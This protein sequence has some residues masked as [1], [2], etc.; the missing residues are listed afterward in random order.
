[1]TKI[2]IMSSD[3]G[4]LAERLSAMKLLKMTAAPK[5]YRTVPP[6]LNPITETEQEI[7][8]LGNFKN[9]PAA[10]SPLIYVDRGMIVWH[11]HSGAGRVHRFYEMKRGATPPIGG[12]IA[13]VLT[14]ADD[15][16]VMSEST[17][18]VQVSPDLSLNF[19]FCRL[20]GGYVSVS[21]ATTSTTATTLTGLGHAGAWVDTR[22]GWQSLTQ[23]QNSVTPTLLATFSVCKKDGITEENLEDGIMAVA[24]GDIPIH[25]TVVN[26]WKTEPFDNAVFS[27]PN[28]THDV[29]QPSFPSGGGAY[30]VLVT[31]WVSPWNI[32]RTFTTEPGLSSF[33]HKLLGAID[34][35]GYFDL[36]IRPYILAHT[37]TLVPPTPVPMIFF[38]EIEV[39][40]HFGSMSDAG[41]VGTSPSVKYVIPIQFNGP[42]PNTTVNLGAVR[43]RVHPPRMSYLGTALRYT[44]INASGPLPG[45]LVP[46]DHMQFVFPLTVYPQGVYE[47]GAVG[48]VRLLQW[49]DV[50]EGQNV[51]VRGLIRY[52]CV[53]GGNLAPYVQASTF[54]DPGVGDISWLPLLQAIYNSD[55]PEFK[56]CYTMKEHEVLRNVI[57]PG[58]TLMSL[59]DSTRFPPV[60]KQIAQA[61]GFFDDLVGGLIQ[62]AKYALPALGAVGGTIAGGPAVGMLGG[63]LG[64]GAMSEISG[65]AAGQYP[66]QSAGMFGEQRG[67]SAGMYGEQG[68]ASGMYGQS[69]G[70]FEDALN[71]PLVQSAEALAEQYI[72]E[73]R[74]GQAAGMYDTRSSLRR[75]TRY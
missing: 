21:S 54:T 35:Y 58:L 52:G 74:I 27:I 72:R 12:T 70:F 75:R 57:L 25:H 43:H 40:D 42:E 15:L 23:P 6:N 64:A 68:N 44:L 51:Q 24:G 7:T 11:L 33:F 55:N 34:V 16:W 13:G 14:M 1:M 17:S 9:A 20:F 4:E 50:A 10:L 66:G 73:K 37:F 31:Q 60:V 49:T 67:S 53:T 56:R 65:K 46:T 69:G 30:T 5:D 22:D 47:P 2:I 28:D 45:T 39:V 36:D 63:M 26:P 32:D 3:K 62:S 71:S 19:T 38:L 59:K 61:A 8:I 41:F 48:P 18:D 29:L